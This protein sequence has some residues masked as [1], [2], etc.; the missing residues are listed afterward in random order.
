MSFGRSLFGTSSLVLVLVTAAACNVVGRIG[1]DES[2][3][4]DEAAL[5][6]G[7][8]EF[9][10]SAPSDLRCTGLYGDWN[11]KRPSTHVRPYTP[12]TPLW[13]DGAEKLRFIRLPDGKK[14]DA[15]DPD[16]W[17]F[18]VGTKAWKEFAVNGRRV[19]TRYFEKVRT[20]KWV[21]ATYV[22]TPDGSAAKRE[23][24]GVT[25]DVDGTPYEVPSTEKCDTCH[26]GRIDNLLGFEAIGL[27]TAPDSSA[28]TLATLNDEQRIDPP[29][30]PESVQIPDDGTGKAAKALAWMHVNCGVSCHNQSPNAEGIGS[31]L[32]LRVNVKQLRALAVDAS[33]VAELDGLDPVATTMNVAT[34]TPKWFDETRIVPGDPDGSLLVQLVESR[35]S[36]QQMPPIAT[37]VV[38]KEGA[39]GLRAWIDSMKGKNPILVPGERTP[40]ER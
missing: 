16:E 12:G 14:I 36:G 9:D 17:V 37:H 7:C 27:A 8:G 10:G 5:L 1:G 23:D 31:D 26:K 19:E 24:N 28:V 40:S 30:P 11:A 21:R 3:G 15:S 6:A 2:G 34:K 32:F 13:S 29:L 18:P 22:W 35:E 4:D 25:V 33:G 39:A 20:D 38:D